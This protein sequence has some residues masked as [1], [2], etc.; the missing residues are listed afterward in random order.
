MLPLDDAVYRI[1]SLSSLP[2][3][4]FRYVGRMRASLLASRDLDAV[5]RGYQIPTIESMVC[6]LTRD[7][8]TRSTPM[9]WR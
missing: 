6:Y 5:A 4:R 2:R 8:S 9:S 7:R 3:L 1:A